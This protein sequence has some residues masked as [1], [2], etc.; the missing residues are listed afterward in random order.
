MATPDVYADPKVAWTWHR[1][2][3]WPA[4][5]SPWAVSVGFRTLSKR[6]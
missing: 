4:G 1:G 2:R 5:S 3:T 6:F